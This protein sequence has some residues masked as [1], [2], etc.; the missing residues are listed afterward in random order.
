[1]N[2]RAIAILGA[3]F[4]LIVGTLG[5]IIWQRS[6]KDEPQ[7]PVEET[8]IVVDEPT[9]VE[10]EPVE[11]QPTVNQATKLT[12]ES[13]ISPALFFQ[14]DGIAY[15]NRQGQLFR[16]S[17]TVS[18]NTVLLSD[19][20]ELSVPAKSDITKVLW[21]TVGNSYIAESGVGTSKTWSYYSPDSANYVNLPS[22]VKSLG[23]NSTGEKIY[24][25]WVGNDGKASLNISDPDTNN[26]QMLTDLYEPDNVI[27]VS[28]DGQNI[29]IYRTQTTDMSRNAMTAVSPDGKTFKALMRDGYNKEVLWSPDSK[30]FLFTRYDSSTS[31]YNMYYYDMQTNESRSLGVASSVTKA[32]W[33]K[34][35]QSI[36]VGV[37]TSGVAN[38]GVTTD[39][40][41]KVDL[42]GTR[43]EFS[44][45]TNV[46]VQEPF[47]SF[48]GNILF[49]RNNQDG[50]LYYLPLK[51]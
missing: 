35:S 44:P 1:M 26:Y 38:S 27:S 19:K 2:K 51:S 21:P 50:S 37:P 17:M 33:A 28:P 14:G 18:D 10:E 34:D 22:Q 23:W 11:E 43:T 31:K 30:K 15:F 12:D 49:F 24:F 40:I 5:F 16:T 48:D 7:Q 46:D 36:V 47:L 3:I 13:I 39:T 25:V 32:T 6:S 45:G 4:I 20:T 9:E 8:P 42:S 41:Y 29:I